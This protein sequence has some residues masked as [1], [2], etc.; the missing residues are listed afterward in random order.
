M[1]SGE[2]DLERRFHSAILAN[3][4]NR[5]ILARL[6]QLALGDAWLVSG[7]LF[8][9]V[10]N[11]MDG[12]EPNYGIKDYDIFYFDADTSWAAED[13]AINAARLMFAD[14]G[15]DVEVRN[16]ARVHLW[17]EQKFGVPCPQFHRACDGIDHFLNT[18]SMVGVA[19]GPEGLRLY[20]PVGLDDVFARIM[21]SNPLWRGNSRRDRYD[22]KAARWK[23][24]WPGLRV[25][26]WEDAA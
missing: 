7:C 23:S 13:R 11:I 1:A 24:V 6:P 5:E 9:T 19:L 18:C 3:P 20:A 21:R 17:Y 2:S 10:W 15:V 16:Q 26:P 25:L 4:H 12:R 22:E 14:L 8:Q